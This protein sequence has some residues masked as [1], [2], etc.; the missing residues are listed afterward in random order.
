[1][2]DVDRILLFKELINNNQYIF[3]D[4]IV[5]EVGSGIGIIGLLIAKAGAKKV[6]CVDENPSVKYAQELFKAN[7]QEGKVEIFNDSIEKVKL[8]KGSVDVI[9]SDWIGCFGVNGRLVKDVIFA[10]DHFLKADGLILPDKANIWMAAVSDTDYC[11]SR[12]NY[13]DNVYGYTMPT[14]K[15]LFYTEVVYDYID[16]DQLISNRAQLFSL[17]IMKINVDELCFKREFNLVFNENAE[18]NSMTLWLEM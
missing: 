9:F 5:M 18:F 6:I 14:M 3:R 1:M 15:E 13:W 16:K 4:K 2:E 17:D 7:G 11:P 8:E 12:F 10:R